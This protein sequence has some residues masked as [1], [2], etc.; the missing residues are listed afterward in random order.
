LEDERTYTRRGVMA[1]AAAV[2]VAA[3][4][5]L[6]S[7]TRDPAQTA[8]A[9]TTTTALDWEALKAAYPGIVAW[10]RVDGTT[11]DLPV[12]QPSGDQPDDW[13]LTHA[14]DGSESGEGSA[15][16]DRRAGADSG[17]RLV[18]GH[19][20]AGTDRMFSGVS[21]AYVQGSFDGLGDMTWSTPGGGGLTLRPA[22]A[23][24]VDK[25]YASVQRF[26]FADGDDMRDWLEGLA[27]DASAVAEDVDGLVASAADV[28]TL[29]TCSSDRAGQR[30]RTLV[31]FVG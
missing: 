14:P 2:A 12:M 27:A 10:L 20:M 31:T 21:K 8:A 4:A 24:S 29:C 18:F 3:V 5:A 1:A 19:H 25:Q 6:L 17:H 28:V 23:M 26:S 7:A 9:P 22:F 30:A 11:I 13:Y 16:L 15:Y